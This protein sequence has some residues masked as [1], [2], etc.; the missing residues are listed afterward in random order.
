MTLQSFVSYPQD[1][2]FPIQNLPFGIF[3]STH[4]VGERATRRQDPNALLILV[5]YYYRGLLNHVWQ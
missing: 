2:H 5:I 1:C 3:N 4:Y